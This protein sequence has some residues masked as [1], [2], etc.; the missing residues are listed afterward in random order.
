[1]FI[2]YQQY[3]HRSARGV[4]FDM[5]CFSEYS[6]AKKKKYLCSGIPIDPNFRPY[7]K[8]VE[9]FLMIYFV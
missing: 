8:N 6:Q 7:P 2:I 4:F 9:I 3:S 5:K 1:M